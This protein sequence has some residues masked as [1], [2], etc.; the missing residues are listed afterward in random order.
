MSH[1]PAIASL[2]E[3]KPAG[4][5]AANKADKLRRITLAARE[6]FTEKGFDGTTLRDIAARADVG[7]GTLF[8]YASN[9]RDLLFLLFN[10]ELESVLDESIAG[11]EVEPLAIDKLMALFGGYYA[12]FSRN[13]VLARAVMRELTFFSEGV[14]ARKFLAHRIRFLQCVTAVIDRAIEAGE[15]RTAKPKHVTQIIFA[16][17]VWEVRRWLSSEAGSVAR[18]LSDLRELLALQLDGFAR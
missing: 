2:A 13:R 11:A 7:F 17:Y 18:G 1:E 8:D 12:M 14:E 16:I 9:K 3:A 5:R 10:P 6:L 4:R 15:L